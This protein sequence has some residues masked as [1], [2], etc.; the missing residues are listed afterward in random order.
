MT[1]YPA[2]SHRGDALVSGG[3]LAF[4]DSFISRNMEDAMCICEKVG[5]ITMCA[6]YEELFYY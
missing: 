1:S 6:M 5:H 3:I 2:F 4:L